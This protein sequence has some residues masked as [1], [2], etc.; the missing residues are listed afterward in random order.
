MSERISSFNELHVYQL[1]F[2]L[3]Q[4]IKAWKGFP[5][6]R[7][8][9]TDGPNSASF[10]LDRR[11]CSG[12]LVK[13]RYVAHLISKLTD[14]DG[15]QAETQ[16]WLDTAVACHYLSSQHQKV[17]AEEM[18]PDWENAGHMMSARE[19]LHR[20]TSGRSEMEK[21]APSALSARPLVI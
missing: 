20:K 4:E 13:R 21:L 18:L 19:K 8:L 1:A 5:P 16:H 9:F 7:T 3:Q 6:R 15:E 2:E 17:T 11:K 10:S 12:S 14:A